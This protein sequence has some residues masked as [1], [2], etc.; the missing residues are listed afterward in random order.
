LATGLLIDAA[1]LF[2]DDMVEEKMKVVVVSAMS[3]ISDRP[4]VVTAFLLTTEAPS[5][6]STQNFLTKF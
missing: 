5:I 1:G 6:I 3:Q 4:S 2:G